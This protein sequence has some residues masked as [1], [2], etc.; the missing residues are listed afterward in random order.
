VLDKEWHRKVDEEV[1]GWLKEH[2]KATPK[3]F[4]TRL[5]DIYS[6]PEMKARFPHGF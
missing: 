3:E 5:R 1:V 2:S 6:R 4:M